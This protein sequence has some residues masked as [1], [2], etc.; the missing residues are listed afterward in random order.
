MP[1]L[2][3][4]I[5]SEANLNNQELFKTFNCGIGMVLIVKEEIKDKVITSLRKSKEVVFEIGK[6]TKKDLNDK[7]I[8]I[9]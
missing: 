9:S 1:Y 5:K 6:I 8:Q 4:W 3:K 2:F 7:Q